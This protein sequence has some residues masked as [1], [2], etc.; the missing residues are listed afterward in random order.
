VLGIAGLVGSGRTELLRLLLGADRASSGRVLIR[1]HEVKRPTPRKLTRLGVAFLGEERAT[2]GVIADFS[3][4]WNITLASLPSVRRG[5]LPSTSIAKEVAAAATIIGELGIKTSSQKVAIQTLSGGNQQ[6][7][8]LGR[9]L[10]RG[11][12]VLLLDE[13]TVGVDVMGKADFYAKIRELAADGRGVIFVS[14]EHAE[15]V[16]VCDRTMVMRE[17]VIVGE[18]G[19]D[20][21]SESS[22]LDLCYAREMSA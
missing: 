9:W 13:P 22:I 14:S 3:V 1:G 17:G 8:L 15:I 20:E 4:R 18:L 16:E 11:A 2:H 21:L 5:R 6:K 19:R 10:A 7:V 12:D